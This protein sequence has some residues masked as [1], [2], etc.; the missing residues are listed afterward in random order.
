RARVAST[1]ELA[2]RLSTLHSPPRANGS[3]RR[4]KRD[5]GLVAA[6]RFLRF[7]DGCER[8]GGRAMSVVARQALLCWIVA[9]TLCIAALFAFIGPPASPDG[10]SVAVGRLLAHTGMAALIGWLL[11]RRAAP[12]R[13][14][15]GRVSRWCM[16]RCSSCWPS[17]PRPATFMRTG[18]R[19]G[20]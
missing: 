2:C 4:R 3:V 20:A 14:G 10:A 13:H 8:N 15:R 18:C 11:A 7:P 9:L 12:R 19:R 6:A 1:A 5:G 17:S 16:L